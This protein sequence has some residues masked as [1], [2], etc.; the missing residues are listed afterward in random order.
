MSY[1]GNGDTGIHQT[2]LRVSASLVAQGIADDEIVTLLMAATLR[3]AGPHARTWNWRREE[4]ALRAMIT[5]ARAKFVKP[6]PKPAPAHLA[7]AVAGSEARV[8]DL[9]SER[10]KRN[11]KNGATSDTKPA[12]GDSEEALIT[13]LGDAV[14]SY[15]L[16]ERGPLIVIAGDPWTYRDGTWHLF[17]ASLHHT[18]RVAIQGIIASTGVAPI[19]SLLNS[20]HRYVIERPL[21]HREQVPWDASGYIVGKN[22][23]INPETGVPAR[24]TGCHTAPT[25]MPRSGSR[26]IS[27][28]VPPARSGFPF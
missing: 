25:S 11:R 2:Q 24:E 18:L 3:A 19:T 26:P 15:W 7:E 10:K 23:A 9:G 12:K 14:I 4:R 27:T 28:P 8:V 17:D 13:R 21:L 6:T 1:L 16:A 20:I 22:G 5:T